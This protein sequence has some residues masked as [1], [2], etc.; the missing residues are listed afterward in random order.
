MTSELVKRF[1]HPNYWF[2]HASDLRAAAGAVWFAMGEQN[3]QVRESL[4][5]DVGFSMNV[6]SRPVYHLL[7]GLA[8]EVLLKA[9]LVCND[10]V[11]SCS[12]ATFS[13]R[14]R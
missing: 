13:R 10:P 6:A 3:E 8:L 9:L 2:N 7:C 5:L 12:G 4:G 14:A 11:I 1:S